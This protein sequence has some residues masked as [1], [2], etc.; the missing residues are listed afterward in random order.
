MRWKLL[1]VFGGQ[2]GVDLFGFEFELVVF[3]V[4]FGITK[5]KK[6]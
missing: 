6:E 1:E 2:M 3:C 4:I 5:K